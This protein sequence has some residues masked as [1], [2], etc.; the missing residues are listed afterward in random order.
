MAYP[1]LSIQITKAMQQYS[2]DVQKAVQTSLTA[3]GRDALARVKAKSPSRTGTY[4]KGWRMQ[5]SQ[6]DGVVGFE[7]YQG[8]RPQLT[9]LLEHGHKTRNRKGFVNAQ[10]HIKDVEAWAEQ[11]AID[12]IAK[13]VSG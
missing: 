6:Q 10:P 11:A 12:A 3:I 1:E 2:A 9:H 4:R 5:A 7:I 13:A 8:S